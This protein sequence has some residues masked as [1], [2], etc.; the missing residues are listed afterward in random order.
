MALSGSETKQLSLGLYLGIYAALGCAEGK[1]KQLKHYSHIFSR[2]V[3]L[4]FNDI[5]GSKWASSIRKSSRTVTSSSV[6]FNDVIFDTTPVGRIL[7]RLGKDVDVID[8]TL[9]ISF[10]FFVFCIE[11]VVTIL[12]VIVISTPIFAIVIVPL[13]VFYYFSLHF[14][15]PTSRQMKRLES[16]NRSP[17]Y[18]HFDKTIRGLVCIRAF[19][20]VQEFCKS[21]ELY[22][23]C[24]TRCK[25]SNILSNRWLAVR[26]EFI[27][28]SV[29]LCASLF[30][31]LSQR[32]DTA[33]NAGIAGL[34]VSYALNITDV[35]NFAVRYIS[36][37]E[38]NI[39]AVE[40]VKEY[41]EASMEAE[42]RI[43]QFKPA[44]D[45]PSKGQIS[46]QNYSTYY[47]PEL[48]LVLRQLNAFITPA[49]KIGIVGRT[50]AGKS[51][52]ALA[53]FR[54][55]EPVKGTILIDGVDISVIG[56]HDLRSNLTIIPQD[57]VIFSGT[58]RFNLDPSHIYSDQ[59]IWAALELADL[60]TF[61][62]NL[63][64]GLEYQI[65][66][67]GEDISVGQRQLIC[68]TRALLRK[69]KVLLLDEATA[70]VDLATDSVIQKTIRR[71]F[72]SSTVLTIAHR[73]NTIIDYDRIIVLEN[74]SIREFDSPQNL[75]ANRSSI[76]YS[77][78]RNAQIVR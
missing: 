72:H 52:L 49:E 26:L 32:W 44:N 35:L 6:A 65:S 34:S 16:T 30:A 67:S 37:L 1:I 77:M 19:G 22:V 20:K 51:S 46:F 68:L 10:R 78:A 59:E 74:G 43:D 56:L 50:G 15:V 24:F 48:D 8:Q 29:V 5:F 60:K 18:Q 31:V 9:P 69:S 12:I 17:L 28:N 40:R 75:L 13:A 73:L 39:V 55:I 76:F 58:L 47:H 33:I 53:L 3:F 27:G 36:E 64:E 23:D 62:L 7:N 71:E 54:I 41:A 66:E 42:W 38:M 57:P 45:W 25:Y 11:S 2:L 14:Y 63:A 61:V 70:A 21:M 4:W